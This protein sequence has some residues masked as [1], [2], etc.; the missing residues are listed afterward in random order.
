VGVLP[1]FGAFTGNHVVLP[2][3]GDRIFVVHD[4]QVRA[5]PVA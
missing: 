1:A 2:Q 4:E 3:P 5:L